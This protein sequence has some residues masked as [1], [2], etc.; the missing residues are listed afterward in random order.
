MFIFKELLKF[1]T[2]K[3]SKSRGPGGQHVNKT[4]TKV[5][6]HMD[7]F[8]W[9]KAFP[10]ELVLPKGRITNSNMLIVSSDTFRTQQQ[11][12]NSCAEKLLNLINAAQKPEKLPSLAK[13]ERIAKLKLTEKKRNLDFKAHRKLQKSNRQL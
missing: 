11:N 13:L 10:Q 6:M 5:E 9:R 8:E 3:H 4:N 7:L 1:I 12:Y 2:V